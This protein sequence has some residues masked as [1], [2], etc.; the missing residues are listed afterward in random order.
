MEQSVVAT[1]DP[2]MSRRKGRPRKIVGT[3]AVT[4]DE[5]HRQCAK[6]TL[7]EEQK[8]LLVPIQNDLHR[9]STATN[10]GEP[11]KYESASTSSITNQNTVRSNRKFFLAEIHLQRLKDTE[12]V[13]RRAAIQYAEGRSARRN[14]KSEG[15]P[16][17]LSPA[18]TDPIVVPVTISPGRTAVASSKP[19]SISPSSSFDSSE[20][21]YK[22]GELVWCKLGNYPFWPSIVSTDRVSRRYVQ[23][24]R[25]GYLTY[26][27]QYLGEKVPVYGWTGAPQR[28]IP[29]K[30]LKEFR[31]LV[32]ARIAQESSKLKVRE[33]RDFFALRCVSEARR[34]SWNRAVS[35]AE[36]RLANGPNAHDGIIKSSEIEEDLDGNPVRANEAGDN[37]SDVPSGRSLSPSSDGFGA[38]SSEA[39]HRS[40][41]RSPGSYSC[42]KGSISCDKPTSQMANS[43]KKMRAQLQKRLAKLVRR[44]SLNSHRPI[45]DGSSD[46]SS[47][48]DGGLSSAVSVNSDNT[49]RSV[50]SITSD[51]FVTSHSAVAG[52]FRK[53]LCS[54]RRQNVVEHGQLAKAVCSTC[55]KAEIEGGEVLVACA[56]GN[57]FHKSCC[58]EGMSTIANSSSSK[59]LVTD[60]SKNFDAGKAREKKTEKNAAEGVQETIPEQRIDSSE[61]VTPE[62]TDAAERQVTEGR[63]AQCISTLCCICGAE[64]ENEE[65]IAAR[66]CSRRYHLHCV[67]QASLFVKL[68]AD[69]KKML[70]CPRDT[71]LSCHSIQ[72]GISVRKS[73]FIRCVKCPA[74]YHRRR[75]CVPAACTFLTA[76]LVLCPRHLRTSTK[77]VNMDWC[78]VCGETGDLVCCDVCPVC[79]HPEC[80]NISGPVD[81]LRYEC[82]ECSDWIFPAFGRV[83]WAKLANYIWWPGYVVHPSDLPEAVRKAKKPGDHMAVYFFGTHNFSWLLL[84]Q[85]YP[86][87][88]D[89]ERQ[90]RSKTFKRKS[91]TWN[92]NYQRA[93]TE[94]VDALER[95]NA[96]QTMK[97]TF[98]GPPKYRHITVNT[99]LLK[100][101][102]CRVPRPRDDEQ[103]CIC[104]AKSPCNDVTCLN[105]AINIECGSG[106]P[107]GEKCQN[108]RFQRRQYK[109]TTTFLTSDGRGW[110]LRS[111]EAIRKDD[112]VIEYVGEVID[113]EEMRRR[114]ERL[115]A[116]SDK[117]VYF[118]TADSKRII[119]AGPAGNV[120]RFIN[121]SC[122]P[123]LFAQK[124]LVRGEPSVGLFAV[125]EIQPGEELVFDYQMEFEHTFRHECLCGAANCAGFLGISTPTQ[126]SPSP[127][128]SGALS[129][130]S[131]TSSKKSSISDKPKKRKLMKK[132]KDPA[133]MIVAKATRT[134]ANLKRR[135]DA[136]AKDNEPIKKVARRG[137]PPKKLATG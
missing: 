129:A 33:L 88:A 113:R 109:K 32:D 126:R 131:S 43:Q 100:S 29:F 17:N 47:S 93:L 4:L 36:Q 133:K 91:A 121:H 112:F 56:C 86:F 49:P 90:S 132:R 64:R 66:C 89:D 80:V 9:T 85:V 73:G 41:K 101:E 15:S 5:N 77:K 117:N 92:N 78:H 21:E 7:L 23:K 59:V 67:Q 125:R 134:I 26:Y 27:V 28:V 120:S 96:E 94:A 108:R 115:A 50:S 82:P 52:A 37:Y 22:P 40:R 136:G 71:C 123:N 81:D 97:T 75:S 127:A 31:R 24:S 20:A 57:F 103:V 11:T 39:S 8:T 62:E 45:F 16:S 3:P 63:C 114:L 13:I 106:C 124:W 48:S 60:N 98:A 122:S 6:T 35:I 72:P 135:Y 30:G 46:S 74:T 99:V 1:M 79:V 19:R 42:S 87:Q 84:T 137:R 118:L 128:E 119:D 83:V 58:P 2:S 110:G 76:D 130:T 69:K 55:L 18:S 38:V 12:E 51:R 107:M 111:E 25:F 95:W 116:E 10:N 68:S 53:D 34:E 44:T 70:G 54:K 65:P 102:S 14:R 105:R 104:T 61:T